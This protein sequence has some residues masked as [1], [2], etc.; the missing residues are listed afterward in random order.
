[1]WWCV[2]TG[3]GSVWSQVR[4]RLLDDWP[5]PE[6]TPALDGSGCRVRHVHAAVGG[7][8]A[9]LWTGAA[10]PGP[11]N[12]TEQTHL[13]LFIPFCVRVCVR[14]CACACVC[15]CMCVCVRVRV[16][17]RVCMCA[18][19]CVCACVCVPALLF[20]GAVWGAGWSGLGGGV[21]SLFFGL[22]T[23]NLQLLKTNKNRRVESQIVCKI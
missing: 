8:D 2:C 6:H 7:A 1:M 20:G 3:G 21:Q 23:L 16:C 17:V 5:R 4:G 13:S 22:Q 15:V 12:N 9:D 18:C 11:A 14:V 19:A 10:E